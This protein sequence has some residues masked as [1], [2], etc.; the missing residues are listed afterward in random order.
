MNFVPPGPLA[1]EGSIPIPF[2]LRTFDPPAP[3]AKP[4]QQFNVPTIWI[5]TANG[6]AWLLTMNPLGAAFW[7]LIGGGSIGPV[8]GLAGNSGGDVFP[9]GGIINVVGDGITIDIVGD[10]LTSTLTASLIGS[11]AAI[12]EFL[13][14][15]GT[16][17]VVP[18][19]SGQ[20]RVVGSGSTTTVGG[21]NT[22]TLQLTGLTNHAVL[23]GAGTTTI[24]K[25]GPSSSGG[26]PLMSGGSS[27]DPLFSTTLTITDLTSTGNGLAQSCSVPG[28]LMQ[29]AAQNTSNTASSVTAIESI[30]GGASALSA[31]IGVAVSGV[32]AG[33]WQ[34]GVLCSNNHFLLNQGNTTFGSNIFLNVD[35]VGNFSCPQGTLTAVQVEASG[36]TGGTALQ[37]SLTNTNSTTISTGT[38]TVKMSSA[39]NANNAAWIKIYIG[40][41]AYW[42]PAW[43]T[44]AP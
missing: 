44:N 29:W 4:N 16:T 32:S 11:G 10:P 2:V 26:A 30:A 24:T 19:S 20:V 35:T 8:Q 18:N 40:A 17:S 6:N 41:T 43:T 37:T 7:L 1:Y 28:G 25:V 21:T 15:S 33:N 5:N 39:N 31:Q 42:I 34:W 9:T 3:S 27:A 14:N 12:E 23:V 36:D 13:P 22:I 38:G